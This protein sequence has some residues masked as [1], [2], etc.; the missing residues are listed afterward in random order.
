MSALA[1]C[2]A[3]GSEGGRRSAADA[4]VSAAPAGP[5]RRY[6]ESLETVIYPL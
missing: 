2:E 1:A 3:G 6:A 5:D 4:N